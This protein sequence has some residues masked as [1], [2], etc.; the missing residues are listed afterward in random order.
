M[1]LSEVS[2]QDIYE[3]ILSD[4]ISPGFM[5]M[6]R[7]VVFRDLIIKTEREKE[8]IEE[9]KIMPQ[10]DEG[11]EDETSSRPNFSNI[12]E[13]SLWIQ[14]LEK[15]PETNF[16]LFAWNKSP[17]TDLEKWLE[18]NATIHEFPIPSAAEMEAYIV[19][20]LK[21]SPWQASRMRERLN[22]DHNF[23]HQEVK[24]LRLA[25]K[26]SWTDE[27]LK[28]VLPN[29]FEENN[30]SI[31][32]PLWKKD[33]KEL[34]YIFRDTLRTADRELTM[35]MLTTMIRKVLIACFIWSNS[36]LPIT[37]GQLSTA[38]RIWHDRINIK[39]LYDDIVMLDAAEKQWES[40]GKLDAF[41]MALL[42]YSD[43]SKVL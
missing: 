22:N 35:A 39:Y 13:D 23:I 36:S 40:T 34:L 20:I 33:S 28:N 4:C 10:E 24:K 9:K 27:E 1:N 16:F 15:A 41:L 17:V 6:T 2:K 29:Y 38:K 5:G 26:A 3:T 42:N 37:P 21:I 43:T 14:T 11:D 18:K 32:N 8:R 12:Y 7:M 30:F 25:E 31:L 19:S